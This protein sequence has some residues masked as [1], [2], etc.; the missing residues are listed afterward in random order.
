M[1]YLLGCGGAAYDQAEATTTFQAI[2]SVDDDLYALLWAATA[3]EWSFDT[4]TGSSGGDTGSATIDGA[5]GLTW[6][7]ELGVGG[8]FTGTIEGPGSWTG[9]TQLEGTY[10]LLV[11][12]ADEWG[13]IWAIDVAYEAVAYGP[14]RLDGSFRWLIDASYVNGAYL[15]EARL[16]GRMR[17]DGG[18]TGVG[19]LDTS[20]HGSLSGGR[21]ALA[22]VGT[23]GGWDVSRTYETTAFRL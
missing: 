7:E 22:T 3:P 16:D 1:M 10:T 13:W 19:V 17:V 15:H 2:S 14:L 8:S 21:Y 6:N 5:K 12:D 23:L 20:T 11:V 9:S 18:A 4:D